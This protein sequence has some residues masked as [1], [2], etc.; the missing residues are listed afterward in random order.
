V[1]SNIKQYVLA[2]LA[3]RP[4]LSNEDLASMVREEFEGANTTPASISSI[5]SNARRAGELPEVSVLAVEPQTP[6]EVPDDGDDGETDEE[7]GL[8]LSRRFEALDRMVSGVIRGVVPA[9]IVS[10]P[11]GLG[12]SYGIRKGLRAADEEGELEYD[13]ISGSITAVGLYM[14]L[15]RMRDGGV[16]V[17]DDAD[18]VFRDETTLNLLKGALDSGEERVISWRKEAHWLDREDMP[19]RFDFQGR[20]IFLTNIDFEEQVQRNRSGAAHF[21][22]LMDR[23]LYLHL[24]LRTLRDYMVR[25]RQVVEGSGMLRKYGLDDDATAELMAYVEE[26]RRRFY[27]LSLRLVHQIALCYLAD[28]ENWRAD[29]E[30][31]KMRAT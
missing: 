18:D 3:E 28:P 9:L 1:A 7:I 4:G 5:K 10:G 15:Y 17:L 19:D 21:R 12:K 31:T 23:S 22:A 20:V 30:M 29:V 25:I 11:P 6:E 26:N 27:H 8:R 2:R 14:A 13:I 24:T 16:V